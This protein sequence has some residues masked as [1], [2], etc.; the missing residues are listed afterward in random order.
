RYSTATVTISKQPLPHQQQPQFAKAN[1]ALLAGLAWLGHGECNGRFY[2]QSSIP[3]GRGYGSSTA[4]MGAVL[5]A[6]AAACERPL[7]SIQATHMAANIEPTDSTL[8]P[9]L[10]MLNHINGQITATLPE[11]PPLVVLVIDPGKVID[12]VKYNH[13]VN[14]NALETLAPT[15]QI[16]FSLLKQGLLLQDW[17]L[18]GKAATLSA[19]THQKILFNPLLD[20]V[21]NLAKNTSALGVCRAHSGSLLGLLLEP[22]TS[23]IEAIFRYIQ[24]HLP[25][26]TKTFITSLVDGGP[27]YNMPFH[28]Y[29]HPNKLDAAKPY[30]HKLET[31]VQP[32]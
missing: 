30:W 26:P 17:N 2:I 18:V 4:D 28:T 23:D 7:S 12:T 3:R 16:A 25:S 32:V 22:A 24:S 8:F 29:S 20:S 21:L 15:H 9:G 11:A 19:T 6:L 5:Y 14:R 1:E 10:V 13:Q 27:R 31:N